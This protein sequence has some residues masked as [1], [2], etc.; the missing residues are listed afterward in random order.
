VEHH[1][2]E[3]Y[4]HSSAPEV[5]L[6]AASQRTKN[7]RLGHGIVQ[8]AP[9][10]NHPARTAERLAMLDLVS[11][12]RVEFGSGESSSEAELGGFAIEQ[13]TKRD[14]WREGLEVAI[15]CMTETPFTGV[16]GD[17]VSMPPRNVVPKPVQKPHP[18][19]WVA[20][21]RRETI[22]LAAEKGI[23]ALSFSFVEPEAAKEWVDEYYALIASDECV[24]AGF[25]V[26]PNFAVVLPMMCHQDEA[27]AIARGIDGAHFFGYSLAHYYVFGEHRPGVTNIWEEFLANRDKRGFARSIVTPDQAPL[28]VKLLQEGLG[29]LRGAVGTPDQIADLVKRYEAAGVD[30]VIFVL[31]AGK[32]LH[33]HICESIELVG[34]EVL[35]RF[36]HDEADRREQEKR[37]RLADACERAL[38]RREPARTL[39]PGSYVIEPQD[40]PRPA[41]SA[42]HATA[43]DGSLADRARAAVGSAF[44]SFV[45]SRSDDQLDRLMSTGPGL[46]VIFKGMESAFVPEKA[47]GFRGEILYEL[48]STDGIR[49]WTLSID[50]ERAVAEARNAAAPAVTVRAAVPVFVRVA[51]GELDP[52]KAMLE[53]KLEVEGDFALVG[54]LGEMFGADPR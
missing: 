48:R 36:P 2:L 18:P 50:G 35:P 45:K 44:G 43:A 13:F 7:I 41:Y 38:A 25:A 11:N 47:G 14:Q 10:Y 3:E 33:E 49:R 46:R 28:G 40:E 24:P 17:Y 32:N 8:T 42:G 19:L 20:C 30:Q 29:S 21:S 52:A 39:E 16:D 6:A 1:F 15:R 51:T 31:Q 12:G 26:N 34:Q 5:F 9:G 54:R 53:G 4:S 37:E 22:R 23:G 27:E